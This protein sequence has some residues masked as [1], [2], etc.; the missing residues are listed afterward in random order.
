M[1]TRT[2]LKSLW[3]AVQTLG[4]PVAFQ[5]AIIVSA[6]AALALM[7]PAYADSENLLMVSVAATPH[8]GAA[9]TVNARVLIQAPPAMVWDMLTDYPGWAAIMPW[10]DKS[11]VL[12][13]T[14]PST[15]MDV[16]MRVANFL[17]T[18]KYRVRAQENKAQYQINMT[19]IS[20]DF[21]SLK[22]SYKLTPQNRGAATLLTYQ[23]NLDT[24]FSMPG[25]VS[26]I[27][28]NTEKSMKA[29][30][31]HAEQAFRKGQIGQ[32]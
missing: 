22:A 28:A 19:R 27:R 7:A 32:Q 11:R 12:S 26:L 18:Y 8:Q 13:V 16:V 1:P 29:F 30:E 9:K 24:G 4:E 20:G 3:P 25:S 17:P 6:M 10:Y 21:K 15:L 2:R 5:K 31:K 14:G 23:L